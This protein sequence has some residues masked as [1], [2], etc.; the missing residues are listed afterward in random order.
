[1]LYFVK[2]AL[3][4]L[5][6]VL[7][8][9]GFFA[10]M[11]V[12]VPAFGVLLM[13]PGLEYMTTGV[14]HAPEESMKM[15]AM[16]AVGFPIASVGMALI[17]TSVNRMSLSLGRVTFSGVFVAAGSFFGWVLYTYYPTMQGN[18]R[19][20]GI[21]ILGLLVGTCVLASISPFLL[22]GRRVR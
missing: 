6:F 5:A 20:D 4:F 22:D 13:L 9:A 8:I 19:T 2:Q 17:G 7:G 15:G 3:W 11:F 1:M 12:A 21:V 14:Y 18:G 16:L 10:G